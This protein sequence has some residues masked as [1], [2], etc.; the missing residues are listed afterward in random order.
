MAF[1]ND[2]K[3][4]INQLQKEP[5]VFT[6]IHTNRKDITGVRKQGTSM[7]E[8]REGAGKKVNKKKN[9]MKASTDFTSAC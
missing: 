8:N 7:A 5:Y 9:A 6:Q 2:P 3:T 1:H 4:G